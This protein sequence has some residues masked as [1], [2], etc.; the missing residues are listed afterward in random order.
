M[1]RR[2]LLLLPLI[3]AVGACQNGPPEAV[4]FV[5]AAGVRHTV[6]PGTSL[7]FADADPN[8]VLSLGGPDVSGPIQFFQVRGI[9]V[10]PRGN[11]WIGDG[12]SNELRIFRPDGSHWKTRGG[13]GEGPGEF[14]RI[15]PLGSFRGDSVALWDYGNPRLTVFDSSGDFVR[16]VTSRWGDNPAPHAVDV[17]P[18]GSILAKK[19]VVLMAGS[20]SPGEL[21]GDT[22]NLIKV[23]LEEQTEERVGL[24][25]G[26]LWVFTGTNQ[27]PVPFTINSPFV[28]QGNEVH[29]ATGERFRIQV[30]HDG[31]LAEEYGVDRNPRPVTREAVGAYVD[32]YEGSI[33]DPG[34]RRKYLSTVDH[35]A[36]PSHLP[37]YDRLIAADDG[38]IWAQVFTPD[39]SGLTWDVFGPTREWM[40]EVE[41][42]AGFSLYAVHDQQLVGV[43]RDKLGVEHV[44]V[45]DL[46]TSGK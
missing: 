34:Q 13:K 12:G 26:P 40:G 11:L 6:S 8:P 1:P 27:I 30:F 18:D 5:D 14:L 35:P 2:A 41:L 38:N 16:T 46:R 24:A 31:T 15:Q 7:T 42:P 19:P 43:W 9:D 28:L 20:L 22:V 17:F 39:R 3:L 29:L 25:F 37:S 23:D 44:R 21:F 10:D 32:L 33:S 45:Y 4:T 36:V